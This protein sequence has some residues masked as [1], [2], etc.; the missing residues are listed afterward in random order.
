MIVDS[1]EAVA[2]A[3]RPHLDGGSIWI[4]DLTTRSSRIAPISTAQRLSIVSGR[5]DKFAVVHRFDS[6]DFGVSA[7]SFESPIDPVSVIDSARSVVSIHGDRA[8]WEDLPSAYVVFSAPSAGSYDDWVKHSL[9]LVDKEA[10]TVEA[11]GLLWY[12]EDYDPMDQP[13]ESVLELPDQGMLVFSIGR[14]SHLVLWDVQS[15]RVIRKVS[16]AGRHGTPQLR[17]RYRGGRKEL[18]ASDYDTLL[19]L[20]PADWRIQDSRRLQQDIEGVGQ[21]I[22]EYAFNKD[23]SLCAVARPASGDVVILDAEQFR[24]VGH[25]Y[26]GQDPHDVA[27]ARNGAVF[28]RTLRTGKLLASRW[29]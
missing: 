10:R 29:E 19:R 3:T 1:T 23:E 4:C 12:E 22:A 18:W 24:V 16:L 21:Y 14:T 5:N 26:T 11:V 15:R 13:I 9:L 2:I 17:L 27:L 25:A 28:A 20:N 6:G 8:I 7:H